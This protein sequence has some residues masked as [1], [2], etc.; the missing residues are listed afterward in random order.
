MGDPQAV[1]PLSRALNDDQWNVRMF[2]VIALG[3]IGDQQA[4]EPLVR[5]LQ[6]EEFLVRCAAATALGSKGAPA[7]EPLIMALSDEDLHV[8]KDAAESLGRIGDRRAVEHL[9]LT[10]KDPEWDVHREAGLALEKLGTRT[11]ESTLFT[12]DQR[13]GGLI[14]YYGL[15][16]WW[17]SFFNAKERS[18]IEKTYRPF[19]ASVGDEPEGC[20]LTTGN[21][22]N[23]SGSRT[24]LLSGLGSW[25][26]TQE[27]RSIAGR[28]YEYAEETMGFL[29]DLAL[30]EGESALRTNDQGTSILDAHFLYLQMIRTYYKDRDNI[31]GALEKAIQACEKQIAIA[32]QAARAFGATPNFH[33]VPEHTGYKQLAIIRDK[34]G[35][36]AAA[37]RLC[38]EAKALGWAGDWDKRIA[39]YSK[40]A[41]NQ[42]GCE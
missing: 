6:D 32:P 11:V 18:Y 33:G 10:L 5:A 39:R 34:Q 4:V 12:M 27:D 41:G 2:V 21:V 17:L 25:F 1:E 16:A 14:A 40:K 35:D 20:M 24:S 26:H 9:A 19:M 7:V 36:Y 8:R 23:A 28:I 22:V 31:P 3:V 13:V 29:S 38:E 15:T 42:A 37:A 30:E